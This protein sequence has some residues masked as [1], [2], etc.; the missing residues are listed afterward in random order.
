MNRG[1]PA[2]AKESDSVG[3]GPGDY[4][5][6]RLPRL[7]LRERDRRWARVREL[8]AREGLDAVITLTNSSAWDHGHSNGRY[9][10]SVGGNCAQVSVVFPF[11][12]PVTVFT[13]PVPT[14]AFWLKRQDWVD[15]IRTGFFNATPA[16]VDRL[17]ELGLERG[18]IG[19]AGLAGV[20]R[21]PDGL[22]PYGAYRTLEHG[23]PQATLVNATF[24]M[25][26]ARFVKGAEEVAMLRRSIACVEGAFEMLAREAR[27]GVPECVVYGRM[28]GRL[29]EQGCEPNSLFL[30]TAGRPVPPAVSTLPSQRPLGRND[31][32]MIELDAKWGGYLG[33]GAITHWIGK[34]DGVDRA[35][36]EL[37]YQAFNRCLAAMRPGVE[38]ASLVEICREAAIGTGFECKPIVHGRGLGN[39]APVLVFHARDERTAR[40]RL[41]KNS[42]FI[43]KPVVATADGARK[44]MWGD[45]VV[46]TATGAKRLGSRPPPLVSPRLHG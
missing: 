5:R 15:D 4:P 12:G 1:R 27:P 19:I 2:T 32:I 39:D 33:H 37:Q 34:T 41:E 36:A 9:L 18:R 22:V 13:G 35:M 14:P 44:V 20:A 38:M 30:W 3:I 11:A 24:L 43:V 16:I 45:T 10:S 7:S 6:P 25:D 31:I 17:R 46:V 28:A 40:W 29:L 23:L 21:A 26:E 8:M 42:A